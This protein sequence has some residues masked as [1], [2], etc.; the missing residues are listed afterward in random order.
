MWSFSQEPPAKGSPSHDKNQLR[1]QNET[2][3]I[4]FKPKLFSFFL[5]TSK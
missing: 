4:D 3:N 5:M 2:K 1:D